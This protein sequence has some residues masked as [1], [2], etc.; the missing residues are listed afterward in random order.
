MEEKHGVS[1]IGLVALRVDCM[2]E[3]PVPAVP[4]H[5]TE[6][7]AGSAKSSS[8]IRAPGMAPGGPLLRSTQP[9][10]SSVGLP[11]PAVQR[12]ESEEPV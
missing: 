8:A 10:G 4:D 1:I 9:A 7:A 12:P 3:P 5:I 2:G 11:E 6:R